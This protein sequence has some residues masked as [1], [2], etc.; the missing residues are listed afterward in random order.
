[1]GQAAG[2]TDLANLALSLLGASTR[3]SNI[4]QGGAVA[5]AARTSL[6]IQVPALQERAPWNF[7]VTR[8][9][10][11][12]T[13]NVPIDNAEY[14]YQFELPADCLRWLPW[15]PGDVHYFKAEQEGNFLLSNEAGPITARWIRHEPDRTKWSPLFAATVV[16]QLAEDMAE[17]VAAD[18]SIRDRMTARVE[19]NIADAKRSDALA[20]G[21]LDRSAPQYLSHAV[22]AMGRG[23]Q[24]DP[25]R[26]NR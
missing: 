6:S 2:D 17:A 15:R 7:C 20:T 23:Y 1:M 11:T 21:N 10:L 13:S 14:A 8:G 5:E 3:L 18:Q 19:A 9:P 22:A 24:G 12:A 25:G 16:A 4:G 26:W